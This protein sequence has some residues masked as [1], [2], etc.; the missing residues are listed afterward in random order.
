[1]GIYMNYLKKNFNVELL[2]RGVWLLWCCFILAIT[3]D[4]AWIITHDY[5]G[6]NFGGEGPTAEFWYY[7]SPQAYG[8][9]LAL[10]TVWYCSGVL[11]CFRK[12]EVA[13]VLLLVHAALSMLQLLA[14]MSPEG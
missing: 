6:Y 14:T 11:L 5:T 10:S 8:A 4:E 1:M 12:G 7:A 9:M 3:I 2:L 13:R